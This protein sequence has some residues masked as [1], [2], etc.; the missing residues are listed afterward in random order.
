M[1]N[2]PSMSKI[3]H[4]AQ[5]LAEEIDRFQRQTEELHTQLERLLPVSESAQEST[6]DFRQVYTSFYQQVEGMLAE[7]QTTLDELIQQQ[8]ALIESQVLLA[9][10]RQRYRDL[11]NHSPAAFLITDRFGII[12][13][14][15]RVAQELLGLS[16]NSWMRSKHIASC[17]MRANQRHCRQ[18]INRLNREEWVEP[19]EAEIWRACDKTIIPVSLT[20]NA[21][22]LENTVQIYWLIQD[23]RRQKEA[24]DYLKDKAGTLERMVQT[25]TA[26]LAALNANLHQSLRNHNRVEKDL[27]QRIKTEHLLETIAQKIRASLDLDDVLSTAV[28]EIRHFLQIDRVVVFRFTP[29]KQGVVVAESVSEAVAPIGYSTFDDP[30]FYSRS[31]SYHQQGQIRAFADIEAADL[32]ECHLSLLREFNV[33]AI[34]TVPLL[35]GD[36]LWGLLI[37]HHCRDSY[38]WE[39]TENELL[40]RLA[41][42]VAI[43]LKQSELY[44]QVQRLSVTDARENLTP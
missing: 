10:E 26:S 7:M 27:Q 34:L 21:I 37:L 20:V 2:D 18:Q 22:Q 39:P 3:Q 38:G 11:F 32:D 8:E 35:H 1:I 17:L 13:E 33:R 36:D 12:Q 43:A 25:R 30:C 44:E 28:Q 15:N 9:S 40:Q 5:D 41:T 24:E 19:W 6:S 14:V 31:L 16:E 29:N 23:L 4:P 42:Q